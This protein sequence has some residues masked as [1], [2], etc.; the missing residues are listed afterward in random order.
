MG[1]MPAPGHQQRPASSARQFR[2]ADACVSKESLPR[3]G[4]ANPAAEDMIVFMAISHTY[5]GPAILVTDSGEMA[6]EAAL[7]VEQLRATPS[8]RGHVTADPSEDF[9]SVF[10][11]GEGRLRLPDGQEGRFIPA[12]TT[13]GSGRMAITGS[14]PAPF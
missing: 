6:V 13:A 9:W 3:C 12:Q 4:G 1:V 2:G 8:W 5:A 10:Q 14:G 11:E 7:Q